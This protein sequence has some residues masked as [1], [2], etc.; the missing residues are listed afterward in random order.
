[1][2]R[3]LAGGLLFAVALTLA[4]VI[5]S[6]GGHRVAGAA[7]TIQLPDDPK[8]GDCTGVAQ[9]HHRDR[10]GRVRIIARAVLCALR[11][12]RGRR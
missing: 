6:L 9:R 10:A 2:D 4:V 3:R 7:A 1:M 8:V 5:P 11:R 12:P